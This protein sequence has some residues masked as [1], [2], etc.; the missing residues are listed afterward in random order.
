MNIQWKRV[1]LP[2][3]VVVVVAAGG[4]V[5]WQRM[6]ASGP[7]EGFLRS[8]GRIEA[9]EID[10]AA[11]QGGRLQDVLVGEGDFVQ[12]GQVLAHLQTDVLIAQ[13][14]EAR[15]QLAQSKTAVATALAQV[16]AR[17]GDFQSAVAAIAQQES[18]LNAARAKYTRSS[19]L[20]AEGMWPRQEL[21][22]DFASVKGAEAATVA[23]RAKA[24]AA[25]AA[26]DAAR[27]QVA[28]A[29]AAVT[30]GEAAVARAE[31]YIDDSTL[32]APRPGR[33]QYRVANVGEI[34]A[35]GGKVLNLVDLSDVYMTFFLPATVAGSVAI[36]SE[37]R[38]V[39]DAAPQYVIPARV[40][41]VSATAQFT[42][43]TVETASEREK[44]MFRVR[45]QIDRE[46]LQKHLKQVKTGLPGVAWM[47]TDSGR[48]WP[49]TL[50][51]RLPE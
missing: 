42:P 22:N 51:V 46:L 47:R 29:Q 1:V 6:H 38:I 14:D 26:I 45:G 18:V 5:A 35:A 37:V 2:A 19:K 7:G 33:V 32:T 41:F 12:Q 49:G 27:S 20:A 15:A 48:D 39:L 4:Y 25:Q 30:A 43:R 44:L 31:T 13:R 23:A 11:K 10:I 17:E 24:N 8:N 40:S 50:Q 21:D 28:G 3:A 16:A 9:T 34:V 36:G